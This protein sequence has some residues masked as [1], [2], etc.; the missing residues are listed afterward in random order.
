M[1]KTIG[2]A[3]LLVA[4]VVGL[5]IGPQAVQA[6]GITVS[7]NQQVNSF[8]DSLK[9]Q[10]KASSP[11]EINKIKLSYRIVGNPASSYA[12]PEF[13]A[14]KSVD[15]TYTIN[16][17]KNYL[18]PQV[19][20]NYYWDIEDAAGNKLRT[21]PITFTLTDARFSWKKVE[22]GSVSLWWYDGT[23]EFANS[24]LKTA[25]KSLEQLTQD[26]GVK[27]KDK[28]KI[29]FYGTQEDLLVALGPSAQEWTGGV[30]FSAQGIIAIHASPTTSGRDFATRAVP[31]E[32]THVVIHQATDNPYGDI[33]QWLSEGLAM[34]YEGSL[35]G[36]Y[37]S[38][39][40]QA[41][42]RNRLLTLK[43][44]S[45]N[46]PADSNQATL[47]YAES[48]SVV[49]FIYDKY[50]KDKMAS[51]LKIFAEGSTYD[52]ALQSALGVT[53]NDLDKEWR[54]SLGAAPLPTPT[55]VGEQ[56][57]QPTATTG[58]KSQP[59]GALPIGAIALFGAAFVT[60]RRRVV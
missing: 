56:A 38:Q 21:E 8:P 22:A 25:T 48:Y 47:S 20:I 10:L 14:G 40:D 50:G 19:D 57:A 31:H 42:K 13:Q 7:T 46:F 32:L 53:T 55:A 29:L 44:I 16:L 35:E 45:S 9:F 60:V 27:A 39:L 23:E 43:T 58:N 36:T 2:R 4:I 1:V 3:L 6:E 17:K 24:M 52:G 30:S 18:P 34:Y 15:T 11:A 51:L 41:V 37:Q 12:Y 59:C 54:A 26:T 5:V 28:V 33:P 49:K